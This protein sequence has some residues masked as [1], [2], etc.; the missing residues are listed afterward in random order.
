MVGIPWAQHIRFLDDRS[1]RDEIRTRV[2]D[3]ATS[4]RSTPNLLSL[5]IG[6]ELPPQIVRWYGPSR[7]EAFLAELADEAKQVDPDALVS[8]ANFPM[9]EY[10]ELDFLDFACFNVYLHREADL[11]LTSACRTS[12]CSGR[13][14]Y[15]F[16]VDSVREG[17]E[18][19]ARVG[20]SIAAAAELGCAGTVVFRSPTS[21]TRWSES[22][23]GRS[24]S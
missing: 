21:G 18:E 9:T 10:L 23:T 3:A 1:M 6:N 19:Q 20:T 8:Y 14:C 24:A 15:Q 13:W 17:D 12:R 7:I 4:L 11:A 5:M 22:P 2:R 16:G